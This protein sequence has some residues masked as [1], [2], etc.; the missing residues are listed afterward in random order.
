LID[1]SYLFLVSPSVVLVSRCVRTFSSF[2]TESL[3]LGGSS[4]K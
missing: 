3:I 2:L 4:M 1:S